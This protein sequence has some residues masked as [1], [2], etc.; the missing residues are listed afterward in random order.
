MTPNIP[1]MGLNA[2]FQSPV[3]SGGN[4]SEGKISVFVNSPV[5]TFHNFIDAIGCFSSSK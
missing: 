5:D 4:L 1:V 3:E 2:K